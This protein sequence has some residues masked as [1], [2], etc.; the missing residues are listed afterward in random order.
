MQYHPQPPGPWGNGAQPAPTESI[1]PIMMAAG[2]PVYASQPNGA[3][4]HS[5]GSFSASFSQQPLGGSWMPP[6]SAHAGHSMHGAQPIM[7]MPRHGPPGHPLQHNTI[8]WNPPEAP[9]PK[10][11]DVNLPGEVVHNART[12]ADRSLPMSEVGERTR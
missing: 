1:T 12:S 5:P 6:V 2:Q 10:Q 3:Q 11:E 7:V 4:L 9:E 8:P